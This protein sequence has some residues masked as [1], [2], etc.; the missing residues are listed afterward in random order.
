M[1]CF[2]RTPPNSLACVTLA[3][4]AG[5]PACVPRQLSSLRNCGGRYAARPPGRW[6]PLKTMNT[7]HSL[8]PILVPSIKISSTR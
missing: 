4:L 1:F 3:R 7:S 2:G 8:P 5:S 6:S